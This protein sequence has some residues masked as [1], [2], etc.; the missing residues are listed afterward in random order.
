MLERGEVD[1]AIGESFAFGSLLLEGIDVR[2]SGQDV[3]RGTFSHRHHVLHDQLVDMKDY[4]CAE[5]WV[6]E[7]LSLFGFHGYS[8][9]TTEPHSTR[10]PG[11]LHC[12]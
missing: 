12:V 7:V 10:Y 9:K 4:R 11:S 2:L 5:L 8:L 3:E 6:V 1:W